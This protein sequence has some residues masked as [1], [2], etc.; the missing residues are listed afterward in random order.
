MQ[1]GVERCL[2]RNTDREGVT[3]EIHYFE[4]GHRLG[5]YNSGRLPPKFLIDYYDALGILKKSKLL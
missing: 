2:K 1:K 5:C 4:D 3:P